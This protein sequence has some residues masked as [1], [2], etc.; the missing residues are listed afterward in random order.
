MNQRQLHDQDRA[1]PPPSA[2]VTTGEE[3]QVP[4]E[5]IFDKADQ[6]EETEHLRSEHSKVEAEIKELEKQLK[7]C[8]EKSRPDL[9]QRIA[10]LRRQL[11]EISTA[12][13]SAERDADENAN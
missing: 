3:G 5:R 4:A 7:D 13:T 6:A 1:I 2:G 10:A 11:E 8:D 12:L 9:E